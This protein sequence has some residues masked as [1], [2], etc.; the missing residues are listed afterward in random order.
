MLPAVGALV[1][2]VLGAVVVDEAVVVEVVLVEVVLEVVA[3]LEVDDDVVV[4][5]VWAAAGMLPPTTISPKTSATAC[6]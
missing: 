3:V 4:L 5:D 1:V 2:E 6:R